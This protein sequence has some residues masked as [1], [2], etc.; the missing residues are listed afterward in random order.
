[1]SKKLSYIFG[2]GLTIVIGTILYIFFCCK[3][4][5][6][7]NGCKHDKDT[8]VVSPEVKSATQ[9]AF[10]IS[11][12]DG[13]F[14]LKLNENFN[15]KTSNF[16]ILEPVSAKVEEGIVKLKDY[17]VGNPLKDVKITG[18]YKSDETNNSVY[19]NLGLARANAVKNYLVL[20]G[21][22]SKQ[23]DTYGKLEDDIVPDETGT[24]FGPVNFEMLTMDDSYKASLEALEKACDAV[25]DNPLVLHFKTGKAAISLTPEQR[26]KMADISHCVD[27]LGVKVLVVGHT[28]NTGNASNNLTLGQK[29]AD[30]AKSYLITNGILKGNIETSSKGQSEPIADNATEE[31][32]AQNRRTV[33]TIN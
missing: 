9:N 26:Q 20:H 14:K 33:I 8:G 3:A 1:M 10:T 32:K 15:F 21:V 25:R 29:R 2:I 18:L 12:P 27:K 13:D 28:D 16:S 6:D 17:L 5:C 22:P 19:P 23:I 30:F 7:D 4:C 31:G 24:L 11:D